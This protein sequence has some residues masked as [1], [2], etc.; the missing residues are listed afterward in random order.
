MA[1]DLSK[2]DSILTNLSAVRN[3]YQF[4]AEQLS[5]FIGLLE[6]YGESKRLE[7]KQDSEIFKKRFSGEIKQYRDKLT[8]LEGK[9]GRLDK[10]IGDRKE[11]KKKLMKLF[12]SLQRVEEVGE[13][14]QDEDEGLPIMNIQ[15]ELDEEGN[16]IRSEV[17]RYDESKNEMFNKVLE[18]MRNSKGKGGSDKTAPKNGP[19]VPEGGKTVPKE[20]SAVPAKTSS[21]SSS[22]ISPAS[23]TATPSFHPYTIREEID[24]DGNIIKSSVR[25]LPVLAEKDSKADV[26]DDQIAQLLEDMDLKKPKIEELE[27]DE[28]KQSEQSSEPAPAKQPITGLSMSSASQATAKPASQTVS[29]APIV[30]DDSSLPSYRPEIDPDDL[31]TLEL[32]ADDVDGSDEQDDTNSDESL[33]VNDST[34]ITSMVPPGSRDML[35][36]KI[37]ELRIGRKQKAENEEERVKKRSK[38]GKSVAFADTVDVKEVDDIWDDLREAEK[39]G[40]HPRVSR[41]KLFRGGQDALDEEKKKE[42]AQA[43]SPKQVVSGLV[44]GDVM[45][46]SPELTNDD[47]DYSGSGKSLFDESVAEQTSDEVAKKDR[48]KPGEGML[49]LVGKRGP[50]KAYL[51]RV[52]KRG[53]GMHGGIDGRSDTKQSK[54]G[55]SAATASPNS[56]SKKNLRSL[57]PMRKAKSS[58]SSAIKVPHEINPVV[59]LPLEDEDFEDIRAGGPDE[60]GDEVMEDYESSQLRP[61][62]EELK[63][64]DKP[65]QLNAKQAADLKSHMKNASL[66][67]RSVGDDM[68]TMARAYVMGLYDDDIENGGEVI[69][70][71]DD[72]KEHNKVVEGL[73]VD[74]VKETEEIK[75]DSSDSAP[76]QSAIVEHDPDEFT[77]SFDDMDVEMNPDNLNTQVALDYTRLRENMI[78]KYNGGFTR[79]DEEKEFEPLEEAPK[80]SRFKAARL[81]L[82]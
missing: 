28:T 47:N 27:E 46:H 23:T 2:I 70:K 61:K 64:S 31:L 10:D 6:Q 66:D 12:E 3:S 67:Y 53:L 38:K 42:E 71:V 69:E 50:N 63:E 65:I 79:T 11:A 45:E 55:S 13:I 77:T 5:T 72:F 30:Q 14:G 24:E 34:A 41:F 21:T 62:I 58:S 56:L 22:A 51:D 74:E 81:G 33:D 9:I 44:V 82:K 54:E 35:F 39:Q 80:V 52:V 40:G 29:S 37:K 26:T 8:E 17:K 49:K 60:D 1:N 36:E 15:E 68:D 76:I 43:K 59:N 57:K 16:V 18:G 25:K 4:E 32:I 7:L 73:D 20:G 75:E 19:G 48:L 78:Q